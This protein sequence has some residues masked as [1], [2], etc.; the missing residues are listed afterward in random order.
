MKKLIFNS[1]LA[2]GLL[3]FAV[4]LIFAGNVWA[5]N[6][7]VA[8]VNMQT[9]ISKSKQGRKADTKLKNLVS[10]YRAKLMKMRKKISA[11]QTDLK[12]N[13]SIMSASEKAKKTKE[14][15]MNISQFTT[16][17]KHIRT[18]VVKKK[19]ELL[20]VVVGKADTIIAK[21]AKNRGYLLVVNRAGVVY[22]VNSI[23]ITD[24]VLKAMNS[25]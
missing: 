2:A 5:I 25:R 19:Y 11:I 10:V 21:I 24:A 16:E 9:V 7:Q 4:A 17:E 3:L 8:V 13:G 12:Q 1:S 23:D 15:E 18:A 14:F 20:K 22:S 6:S